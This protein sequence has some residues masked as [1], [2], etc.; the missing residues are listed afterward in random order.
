MLVSS[1]LY[2]RRVVDFVVR[3]WQQGGLATQCLPD[4]KVH[5]VVGLGAEVCQGRSFD[6][7]GMPMALFHGLGF[8]C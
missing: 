4:R 8:L 5:L 2:P 1:R 6:M 7:F 3:R